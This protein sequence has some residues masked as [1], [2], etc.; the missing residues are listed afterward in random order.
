MEYFKSVEEYFLETRG[1]LFGIHSSNLLSPREIAQIERWHSKSIPLEIVRTGIKESLECFLS[2]HPT[3]KDDPPNIMYCNPT[4]LKHNRKR[5]KGSADVSHSRKKKAPI[6]ALNDSRRDES[7]FRN[8]VHSLQ[9][10]D[11]SYRKKIIPYLEKILAD[12]E[13]FKNKAQVSRELCDE[14]FN[15]TPLTI[16]KNALRDI[17]NDISSYRTKMDIDSY[18]ETRKALIID[19][20]FEHYY[21]KDFEKPE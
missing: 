17:N 19:F 10:E 15:L 12:P 16:L 21:L 2:S 5:L 4:V 11:S 7:I 9:K 8:A 13:R 1:K 20:L 3:R 18:R 14:L 6:P